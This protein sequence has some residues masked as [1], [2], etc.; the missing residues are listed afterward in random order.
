[1][2]PSNTLSL[3]LFSMQFPYAKI[4][5]GG[6]HL[7]RSISL[8]GSNLRYGEKENMV[9]TAEGENEVSFSAASLDMKRRFL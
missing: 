4:K 9:E 5:K 6:H 1:M 2:K 7:A 3:F 8:K